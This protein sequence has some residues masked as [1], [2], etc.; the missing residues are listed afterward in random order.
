[1]QKKHIE[2]RT[3]NPR[4]YSRESEEESLESRNTKRKLPTKL[5]TDVGNLIN[6]FVS[7]TSNLVVVVVVV[8]LVVVVLLVLRFSYGESQSWKISVVAMTAGG[9]MSRFAQFKRH[10]FLNPS[11]GSRHFKKSLRLSAVASEKILQVRA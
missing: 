9:R 11:H 6:P 2:Q 1:M 7:L 4:R 8:F 10:S 3:R 5:S